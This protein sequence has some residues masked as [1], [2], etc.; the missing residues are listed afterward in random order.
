MRILSLGA[1]FQFLHPLKLPAN[2]FF[3]LHCQPELA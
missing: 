1:F 2:L 3:L